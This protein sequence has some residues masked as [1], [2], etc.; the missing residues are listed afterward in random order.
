MMSY[1][2]ILALLVGLII[3]GTLVVRAWHNRTIRSRRLAQLAKWLEDASQ[4]NAGAAGPA[5]WAWRILAE[6]PEAVSF[7]VALLIL[8]IVAAPGFAYALFPQA[9]LPLPGTN[10]FILSASFASEQA[11]GHQVLSLSAISRASPPRC[12][13]AMH[14]CAARPRSVSPSKPWLMVIK[15]VT[16]RFVQNRTLARFAG[17]HSASARHRKGFGMGIAVG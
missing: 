17:R 4:L 12:A 13:G 15:G 2:M 9:S 7:A 16:R 11:R 5:G 14:H 6:L 1:Q 8:G 3:P 10:I